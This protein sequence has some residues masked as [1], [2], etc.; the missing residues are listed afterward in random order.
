M[1]TNFFEMVLRIRLWITVTFLLPQKGWREKFAPRASLRADTISKKFVFILSPFSSTVQNCDAWLFIHQKSQRA[2]YARPRWL[3]K[4]FAFH[5]HSHSPFI[6]CCFFGRAKAGAKNSRGAPA[7]G[8]MLFKKFIFILSPFSF[9]VQNAML[10][11]SLSTR[12]SA[13]KYARPRWLLKNFSPAF[14]ECCIKIASPR[15]AALRL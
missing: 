11:F 10:F 6:R 1:K 3:F 2:K 12:A 7:L 15:A 9:T 13:Q 14:M 5:H 8:L 4:K